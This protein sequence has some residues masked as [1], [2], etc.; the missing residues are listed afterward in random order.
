MAISTEHAGSSVASKRGRVLIIQTTG[1]SAAAVASWPAST[2]ALNESSA[3]ATSAGDDPNPKLDQGPGEAEAV[4]QPEAEHH[5]PARL[6]T[7][8]AGHV[9]RKAGSRRRSTRPT[10]R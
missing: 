3:S 2:P 9:V 7:G 10:P 1:S 5:Q 8:F 4:D 6:A